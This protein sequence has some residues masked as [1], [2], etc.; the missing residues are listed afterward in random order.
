MPAL[1]AAMPPRRPVEP[2]A[3]LV[4]LPAA[5]AP[6]EAPR[7]SPPT[8]RRARVPA[9]DR[10]RRAPAPVA[11]ETIE[12][13]KIEIDGPGSKHDI[14]LFDAV[15]EA[16]QARD[17]ARSIAALQRYE[18]EMPNTLFASERKVLWIRAFVIAR[19]YPEARALLEEVRLDTAIQRPTIEELDMILNRR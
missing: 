4:E 3:P 16:L 1:V 12:K 15:T 17:A 8:Q 2:P 10:G 7:R 9:P 19:R 11:A 6:V 5:P 14:A 13:L 18:R